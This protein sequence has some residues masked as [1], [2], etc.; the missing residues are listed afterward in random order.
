MTEPLATSLPVGETVTAGPLRKKILGTGAGLL[1]IGLVASLVLSLGSTEA[2]RRLFF[3]YV[4]A[5][6]WAVTFAIG[7]LFFVIIHHLVRAQWSTTTRRLA[8]IVTGAFPVLGLCGLGFVVPVLLGYEGLY[9]WANHAAHSDHHLHS[10]LG[11][12]LNP[13]FFALRYVL[14]FV[15]YVG[16]SMYFSHWSRKQDETGDPAISEKLRIAAGPAAII[17]ALTTIF[18]GFDILMS[19]APKWY[20]TIYSVNVW[21]GAMIAAY[22][23]LV[24]LSLVV[25]KHGRLTRSI[26]T[27]HYHDLGKWVFAYTFFWAYTA[28]SQFM[29]IW[30]A[31]VPEE[32]VFYAYRLFSEWRW[33]SILLLVGH[34]VIPFV[35]LLSRWSKRIMPILVFFCVWQ[36]LFHWLDLYWNV[37]PHYQWNVGPEGFGPLTGV[38]EA[39]TIGF[40]PVD[41]TM[42]LAMAGALLLGVGAAMKGN[43]LAIRDPRLAAS[44]R[45]EIY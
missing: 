27:E 10:K 45:H 43:L 35:V 7:S 1:I 12:W 32:T 5:W 25:Q 16:V 36:V 28:F 14:F 34:W 19:L 2:T 3:A 11:W 22:A 8:E 33:V 26:T 13:G 6:T 21:G 37:M 15:L 40:A 18:F 9:F 20:S 23:G 17:Y 38:H 41:L 4:T 42:W 30:Y 31:N 39:H 29:L 24:L 44:L